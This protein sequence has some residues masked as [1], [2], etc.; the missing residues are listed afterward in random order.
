MLC[1]GDEECLSKIK[2]KPK[3]NNSVDQLRMA[4]MRMVL[5]HQL[6]MQMN[7]EFQQELV[8]ESMSPTN[9]ALPMPDE[10]QTSAAEPMP[11]LGAPMN[12]EMTP[13]MNPEMAALMMGEQ[14]AAMDNAQMMQNFESP[15][16]NQMAM[17]GMNLPLNLDG[18]LD[19][20]IKV[21]MPQ[22]SLPIMGFNQSYDSQHDSQMMNATFPSSMPDI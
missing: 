1:H 6:A 16:L 7:P 12:S 14:M 15:E 5:E 10:S 8:K 11:D 21:E 18:T 22:D 17:Y 20:S 4:Y 19:P 13:Q 3:K 9:W 2:R